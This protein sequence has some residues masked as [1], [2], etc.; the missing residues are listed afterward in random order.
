MLARILKRP[1]GMWPSTRA[2]ILGLFSSAVT[3]GGSGQA[4]AV[5][6]ALIRDG[7]SPAHSMSITVYVW[8]LD[9][10]YL[11]WSVPAGLLIL[12]RTTNL[13]EPLVGL[14][15]RGAGGP[16]LPA[17]VVPVCLPAAMAPPRAGAPVRAA[18]VAP[19]AAAAAPLPGNG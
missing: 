10:F 5:V 12:S 17:R 11:A 7:L 9:L 8:V 18:L 3:P 19:L 14:V 2:Y 16:L 13:F 1:L 4:P 15:D 6:L